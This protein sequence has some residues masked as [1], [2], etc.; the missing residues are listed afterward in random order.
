MPE[1]AHWVRPELVAQV[2]FSEWTREGDIRH[3]S[4]KG[5]RDDK[6]PAEVVLEQAPPAGPAAAGAEAPSQVEAPR[7]VEAPA[8][9]AAPARVTG[10]AE[11]VA[12]AGTADP[13]KAVPSGAEIVHGIT[14]T[15]PGKILW[16]VD[17]VTKKGLVEHYDRV[18]EWMLPY[19]LGRPV[20]M[21][22]CPEGVDGATVIR[23]NRGRGG[24]CFFHKHPG[25]DFP[26]PFER[27]TIE[28]S[29]GP[30]TYL[31]ITEAGS[32]AGLAQMGVLEIH[33]WG[34]TWP[35]IEHPDLLVFDLDPDPAVTWTG[36]VDGARLMRE[37][38]Q[39]LGLES[40]VKTTGGKGLHVEAPITPGED[41]ETVRTF[42]KAV[43]EAFVAHAPD[44]YT[45][46]MSKAKRGGKIYVDYVRNNRGATSIAPYS[47]RAKDHATVAVPLRWTE[48][49]GSVRPDSYT[50]K[51]L[52][53]RLRRL[54]GDPWEGWFE[55]QQK[56]SLTEAMKRAVGV[57]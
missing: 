12:A 49:S 5:L 38:L 19:V 22:R 14:L 17:G 4:F 35:D 21:V 2:A 8:K 41:W 25:E 23:Q 42:C 29:A 26:G 10:R 20:S 56:Q 18:A 53:N 7:Q 43:A 13:A 37:V 57:E 3:A 47:T 27:V 9:A 36:L 32:L 1:G 15:H 50:V 45:A 16:P 6:V 44:R 11:A 34:S 28:E 31:T 52:E 30:D 24:P 54:K 55:V 46:N 51:N 39:A 33:V 40:F 48:L